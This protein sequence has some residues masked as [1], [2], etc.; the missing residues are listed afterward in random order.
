MC[1]SVPHCPIPRTQLLPVLSY[2]ISARN[3]L[4]LSFL[5]LQVLV[6]TKCKTG[7]N[8]DDCVETNA[9]SSGIVCRS[10]SR[11]GCRDLWF[12]VSLLKDK[13]LSIYSKL[14]RNID[15]LTLRF[16]FPMSRP[17]RTSRASSLCPTS[18]KASVASCPPTSSRTS[19]PPLGAN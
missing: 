18:S 7:T 8:E 10:G 5:S 15:L 16:K 12:W 3:S 13:G 19:S 1:L 9:Q 6:C 17:S 14:N 4:C 2:L 11:G